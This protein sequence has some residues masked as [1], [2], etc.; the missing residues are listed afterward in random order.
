VRESLHGAHYLIEWWR[1]EWVSAQR[2]GGQ[3]IRKEI[4]ENNQKK[5][6]S[7]PEIGARR[8]LAVVE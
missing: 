1:W 5:M 6:K 7:M 2:N 8:Q 3:W 4:V